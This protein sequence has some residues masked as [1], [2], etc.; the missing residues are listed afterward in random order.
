[1]RGA[2]GRGRR[3]VAAEAIMTTSSTVQPFRPDAMTPAQL[4]ALS[5]LA[6]YS[7]H[8]NALYAY[9]LRHWLGWCEVNGL[10]ALVG[11]QRAHVERYIRHLRDYGL[12]DSPICTMMHGVRGLFRFAHIEGL[13][14]ADPAV[15]VRL[16]KIHSYETRIQGLDR[17]ELIR[18][19]QVAQ[20]GSSTL[21]GQ[22][23][24]AR[25]R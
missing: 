20:T 9:R 3:Q 5:Y 2:R 1:V 24:S 7:G 12:R 23:G 8:T 25:L 4:A 17:L 11:V 14:S 10:D 6:R 15:Y 19:L 21:T 13:I 22:G 18:F 16:P